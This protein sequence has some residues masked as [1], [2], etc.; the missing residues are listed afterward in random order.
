MMVHTATPVLHDA[1][2]RCLTPCDGQKPAESRGHSRP[3]GMQTRDKPV[4]KMGHA[5]GDSRGRC[6]VANLG[7]E[8]VVAGSGGDGEGDGPWRR[9]GAAAMGR[10]VDLGGERKGLASFQI[11]IARERRHVMCVG[12]RSGSNPGPFGSEQSA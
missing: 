3:H 11:A 6:G 5:V 2:T 10:A 12:A 1:R 7:C 9:W 8:E 4:R